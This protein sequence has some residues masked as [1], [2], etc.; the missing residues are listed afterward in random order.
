LEV[1]SSSFSFSF[2]FLKFS[3]KKFPYFYCY[4]SSFLFSKK[5]VITLPLVMDG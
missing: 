1:W 2:S 4:F 3:Q 5:D